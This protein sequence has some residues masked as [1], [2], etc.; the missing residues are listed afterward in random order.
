[1]QI[2]TTPIQVVN[3][4]FGA[5]E[6]LPVEAVAVA[7]IAAAESRYIRPAI[8]RRLHEALLAGGHPTFVAEFLAPAVALFTRLMI[9]PRLAVKTGA[10]G[11]IAPKS[12]WMEPADDK[13]MRRLVRSL[14]AEART[15]LF[16]AVEELDHNSAA[17]PEYDPEEG[18]FK[19]CT[20][21]GELVQSR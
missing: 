4:A 21:H 12:G 16:R 10:A 13:A 19:R 2:L 1:M 18:I 11:S 3:L 8:G 17:Y 5:A 14:H 15:L 20:I 7:D 6:R 9:Q